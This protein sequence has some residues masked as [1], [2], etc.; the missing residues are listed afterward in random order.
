MA[1]WRRS[2]ADSQSN[3]TA[4]YLENDDNTKEIFSHCFVYMGVK[5][6]GK[7]TDL[8]DYSDLY[9][10]PHYIYCFE[11]ENKNMNDIDKLFE[12][13]YGSDYDVYGKLYSRIVRMS[14]DNKMDVKYKYRLPFSKTGFKSVAGLFSS[15]LIMKTNDLI[16]HMSE[17]IKSQKIDKDFIRWN[18]RR[19]RN[20]YDK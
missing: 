2:S 17:I 14:D 7:L 15:E 1:K 18:K 9:E 6:I 5:I 20:D 13:K 12:K 8:S 16:K 4:F 10:K 19:L 11:F 3:F